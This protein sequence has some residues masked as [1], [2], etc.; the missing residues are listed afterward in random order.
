MEL[1][2]FV[3]LHFVT[4]LCWGVAVGLVKNVV[5]FN[6]MFKSGNWD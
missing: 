6:S 2:S 3:Y 5:M 4:H 1:N